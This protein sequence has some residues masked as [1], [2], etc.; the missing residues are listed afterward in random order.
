MRR[1]IMALGAFVS[2]AA[3]FGAERPEA[4]VRV[5]WPVVSPYHVR[6]YEPA[7]CGGLPPCSQSESAGRR[8]TFGLSVRVP[9][10]SRLALRVMPGWQR[11]SFDYSTFD[12]S[13]TYSRAT[14]AN[15]WEVPIVAEWRVAKHVRPGLGG[16]VSVVSGAST[17]SRNV[18]APRFGIADGYTN[19]VRLNSLGR[20]TIGGVVADVEFPFHSGIVTIAPNVQYT[21]WFLKHF[22]ERGRLDGLTFGISLRFGGHS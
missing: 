6:G 10:G 11:V 21:R 22:G 19:L 16:V 12:R 15:R 18:V 13:S 1:E 17:L 3:V 5:E 2:G 8:A 14:T 7:D 9:L 20:K 4:G